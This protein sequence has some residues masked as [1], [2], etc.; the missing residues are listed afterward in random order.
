VN[1]TEVSTREDVYRQLWKQ[2][3]E[4]VVRLGIVRETERLTIEV[5]SADRAEFYR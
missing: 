4:A 5:A 2:S 1:F 3:A